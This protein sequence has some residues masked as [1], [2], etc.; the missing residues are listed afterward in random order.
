MKPMWEARQ[1][2]LGQLIDALAGN[3]DLALVGAVD[4]AE[5]IEQR[6]L[7]RPRRTHHRDEITARYSKVEMIENGDRLLALGEPLA[8]TD[9]ADHRGFG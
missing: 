5:Q 2:A 3:V 4:A 8:Q 6:G 7:S 9:K 1:R